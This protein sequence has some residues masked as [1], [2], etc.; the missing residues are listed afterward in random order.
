MKVEFRKHDVSV[1]KGGEYIEVERSS[2]CPQFGTESAERVLL[3][4]T[5]ESWSILYELLDLIE[6]FAK[7]TDSWT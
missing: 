2:E 4:R 1:E 6:E 5:F 3:V 7:R